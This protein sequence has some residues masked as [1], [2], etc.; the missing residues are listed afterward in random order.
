[1]TTGSGDTARAADDTADRG[2]APIIVV[3]DVTM[4]FGKVEVLRGATFTVR[5]GET[6]CILGGSGGGKSTLLKVMIGVYRPS[7]EFPIEESWYRFYLRGMSCR[8]TMVPRGTTWARMSDHLP[9][10]AELEPA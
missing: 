2:Q 8:S 10:V 7:S 6:L 5:P 4:R 1:M 9:L 3:E